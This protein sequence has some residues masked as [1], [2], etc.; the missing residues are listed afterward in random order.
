MDII[1]DIEVKNGNM[2]KECSNHTQNSQT[3]S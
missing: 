2:A 3:Y 1:M